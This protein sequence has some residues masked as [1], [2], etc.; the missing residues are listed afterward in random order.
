MINYLFLVLVIVA[1]VILN[2]GEN[3]DYRMLFN[4]LLNVGSGLLFLFS[5]LEYFNLG[6]A[7]IYPTILLAIF[8][9]CI[10]KGDGNSN[11]KSGSE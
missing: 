3:K 2:K 4:V 9:L 11:K 5:K 1:S 7:C 8:Y 10:Y 6:L